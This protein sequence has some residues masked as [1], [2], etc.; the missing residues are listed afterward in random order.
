MNLN[1]LS[2]FSELVRTLV[3]ASKRNQIQTGVNQ[4]GDIVA[5]LSEKSLDK[6]GLRRSWI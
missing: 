4:E 1:I 2:K 5:H 3:V 6:S